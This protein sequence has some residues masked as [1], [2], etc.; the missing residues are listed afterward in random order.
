VRD[1]RKEQAKRAAVQEEIRRELDEGLP[2]AYG[3]ALFGEK[4]DAVFGHVLDS[5]F[6]DR[7]SVYSHAA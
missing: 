5:Y 3:R 2:A 7:T 1:W 4:A 6:D